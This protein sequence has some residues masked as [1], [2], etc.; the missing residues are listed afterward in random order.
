[1]SHL[2]TFFYWL[3][4]GQRRMLPL[5][6]C[7][8]ILSSPGMI[9]LNAGKP[10][11]VHPEM[12]A[13]SFEQPDAAQPLQSGEVG[14]RFTNSDT[15][16][17][18]HEAGWIDATLIVSLPEGATARLQSTWQIL[19]PA[20]HRTEKTYING[21]QVKNGDRFSYQVYWPGI[22]P[23]DE[24][25]EIHLGGALLNI[26]SGNALTTTGLDYYWYDWVCQAAPSQTPLP[27]S[28][29]TSQPTQ[30][31][32]ATQ[33]IPTETRIR[34]TRTRIPATET[35]D[36]PTATF[37]PPTSTF[38]PPSA[39]PVS[40]S[41]TAALRTVTPQINATPTAGQPT[42]VPLV[43][44]A[45]GVPVT[46]LTVQQLPAL[47]PVTGGD[48]SALRTPFDFALIALG[49]LCVGLSLYQHFFPPKR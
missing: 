18:Q 47:F 2:R 22:S 16:L 42:Q 46:S 13:R 1:M 19:E 44:N 8:I 45:V 17:C 23:G 25:V 36:A 28:T 49:L 34:P 24:M 9:F 6:S 7:V 37:V 21:G 41:A 12:Q 29:P 27:T 48:L 43:L 31:S 20:E 33:P 10:A 5:L 39:T 30:T 32:T 4:D 35:P 11:A 38:V 26:T 15:A 3:N 14:L 40:P